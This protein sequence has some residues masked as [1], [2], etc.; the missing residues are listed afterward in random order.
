MHPEYIGYGKV[1]ASHDLLC[2]VAIEAV[3]L[4]ETGRKRI[5]HAATRAILLLPIEVI[6]QGFFK[7]R[8][9]LTALQFS[10]LAKG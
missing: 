3:E 10:Q 2:Q 8:L 9:K 4:G 6:P 5:H 1:I 7:Y